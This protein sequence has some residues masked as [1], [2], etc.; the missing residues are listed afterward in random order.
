MRSKEVTHIVGQFNRGDV[1]D[2][3][4]ATMAKFALPISVS[5]TA[6]RVVIVG[7]VLAWRIEGEYTINVLCAGV[8]EGREDTGIWE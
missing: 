8:A 7:A 6:Y 5:P 4:L 2:L 3:V 1:C